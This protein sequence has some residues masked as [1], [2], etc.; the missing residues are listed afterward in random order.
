MVYTGVAAAVAL[1]VINSVLLGRLGSDGAHA[2]I[3]SSGG[4]SLSLGVVNSSVTGLGLVL[5]LQKSQ[6]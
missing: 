3:K 5:S 1:P 6:L 4:S 2:G